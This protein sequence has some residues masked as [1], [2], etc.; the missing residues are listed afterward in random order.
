MAA[1]A[2]PAP[3]PTESVLA[4]RRGKQTLALL[5]AVGFLDFVDASIVNVALPSIRADLGFTIQNLQWVLGG[6]LLTYGGLM[7]LGGRAADLIGRRRLLL[8]GTAVFLLSS[9]GAGLAQDDVALVAFR[10]IQGVGAA[11]MLP[12][13]L[14]LLTTTFTSPKDR[15]KA[16]GMW[17]A[18]AGLASAVGVFL[19]GL[20]S[21]GPGWRWV[22]FVNLPVCLAVLGATLRLIPRDR[23]RDRGDLANF[24]VL[25]ALL[26]T[27]SMLLLVYTIVEAPGR[28]WDATGTVAG[29]VG[30]GLLVLVFAGYELRHRNPLVPFSIFRVKGLVPADVTQV[31]AMA[32]FYAMFFFITLYMQNVLR[33]SEIEAGAAY[34][35][36]T[37]GVAIAA[38]V[39]AQLITRLGTRPVIVTGSLL[40]A[41]G[42][43]WLSRIPADGTFLAD[44]LGPLLVLAAGLGLVF[45]GVTT[46]A[47]TGVPEET[48]GLAAALINASTW[49]G[50]ALGVAILSAVATSRTQDVA[51]TG[52]P[53]AAALTEGFQNA[54]LVA[55][56]FLLAAAAIALRAT[57]S[58]PPVPAAPAATPSAVATPRAA[59]DG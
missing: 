23:D 43:F 19:G 30:S 51:A 26:V 56:M 42:L 29:L 13:A 32:G 24:D 38:G 21:A 57:N 46:A 28:G 25:G 7:L 18:L 27:A 55:A 33:F 9:A 58:R 6:Y 37:F 45:V 15:A 50:G 5:C 49:L 36:T 34:L 47:Q 17:G 12:A 48:A 41:A 11:A 20:I 8:A 14:S 52:A 53:E 59:I 16:L 2:Q 54:L 35:P 39:G 22:F 4:T 3:V 44:L 40:G 31:L 1:P 10:L